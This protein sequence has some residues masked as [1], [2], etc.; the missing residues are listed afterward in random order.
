MAHYNKFSLQKID[1]KILRCLNYHKSKSFI[2]KYRGSLLL[3]VI[4]NLAYFH[5]KY[6]T[7]EKISI[8]YQITNKYNI[9]NNNNTNK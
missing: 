1:N 3:S 7:F 4:F 9:N 8:I 5:Q 2:L 6:G